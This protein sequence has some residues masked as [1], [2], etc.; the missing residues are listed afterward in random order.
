MTPEEL[1][2]IPGV[3]EELV[4]RIQTSVVAYYSQ[5]DAAQDAPAEEA[6]ADP[7]AIEAAIDRE[8]DGV[9]HEIFK[10]LETGVLEHDLAKHEQVLLKETAEG[11]VLDLGNV[12][13]LSAAPSQLRGL[14]AHSHSSGVLDTAESDTMSKID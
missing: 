1:E 14:A 10:N 2:A 9:H 13:G 12:E 5:Y 7:V 3:D 4:T 11:E 6:P 8:A